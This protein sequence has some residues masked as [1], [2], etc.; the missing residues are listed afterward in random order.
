MIDEATRRE[1]AANLKAR[2]TQLELTQEQLAQHLGVR[3][4]VISHWENGQR[5][6]RDEWKIELAR[7]LRIDVRTL[8]PLIVRET[9]D[10]A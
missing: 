5:A 7:H 4:P 9:E 1:W 6:P 2:R 3:Q 10:V 8:F